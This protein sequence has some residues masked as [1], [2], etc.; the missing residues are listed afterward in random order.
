[1][2]GKLSRT[3]VLFCPYSSLYSVSL[4][5]IQVILNLGQENE[6]TILFETI[7]HSLD[8][9]LDYKQIKHY[10]SSVLDWDDAV[11]I[12]SDDDPVG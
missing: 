2:G 9:T 5:V 11:V 4:G 1:M 6:Q 3:P 12:E 8:G 7:G 10:T